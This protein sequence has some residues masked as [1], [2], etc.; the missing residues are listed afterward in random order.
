MNRSLTNVLF[1]GI[2]APAQSQKKIEGEITQTTIEDTAES[3][4]GAESV[5]IVRII[6]P[7]PSDPSNLL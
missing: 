7:P 5:I 4:S 6:I 3:L 2:S 1:G